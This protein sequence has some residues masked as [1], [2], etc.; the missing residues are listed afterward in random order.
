LEP[1]AEEAQPEVP[2]VQ[3][4]TEGE[5]SAPVPQDAL[6][7]YFSEVGKYDLLTRE[8]ERE[9][10]ILVH[11]HNDPQ[12]A[13]KLVLSNLRLVVKIAMEYRRVW[14]SLLDLIQEGNVGL[15]QGVKRF[16]PY[17]G[18]KLSSYAAY[19]IRAYILKYLIDNIRMVRVG[20]SRA[21]RKLFFRL[22]KARR[23]LERE[24]F[25]PETRLLAEKIGV[26]DH[27]VVEMENRLAQGDLS[28]EAPMRRGEADSAAF[29]DFIP[30]EDQAVDDFVAD[31]DMRDTFHQ[32]VDRFA[33]DLDEREQRILRERVL[34][35]DPKTLQALGDEFDLTRER[36]RQIEKKLVNRLSDYLRENLVDFELWAPD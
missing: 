34:S 28:L 8:E 12:A 3:G 9:L 1:G 19:W 29:G 23:E 13:E 16:D 20:S 4:W 18:V 14:T 22:N 35:E 7:R 6:S 31:I 27:E 32:H 17:R 10:A 5:T 24:G 2:A 30:S 36:V 26:K 15:L 25:A 33:V 11:D 21:Q